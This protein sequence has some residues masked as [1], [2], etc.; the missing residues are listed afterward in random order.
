MDF[1]K[2]NAAIAPLDRQAM[3]MARRRWDNL[4]KPIGSMGRMEQLIVRLAGIYGGSGIDIGKRALLVMCADNGVLAQ[5]VAQTPAE[6]TATMAGFIADG[7][8][9]AALMA[10]RA[11]CEVV[12]VDMGMLRKSQNPR[13][14]DRRI[15]AATN[16]ISQGAAMSREQALAAINAGV[17]LVRELHQ[18]GYRL[19][20]TGEMGIGNTTTTAAMAAALLGL[21]PQSVTGRG[22]G[23]SDEGLRNKQ[24][25]VARALAV[26]KPDASDALDVLHKLGG[27]DIA[28]LSGV[29]IGGALCRIPVLVDGVISSI[30][31]LTAARLV[32]AARAMMLPS[33]LSAEPCARAILRELELE[34]VIDGQMRLGEGSGAMLLLP[35]LDLTLD[36]YRRLMTFADIGM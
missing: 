7:R 35:L 33:H 36:V 10:A 6:I 18:R 12:T 17:E 16:D 15:A 27:F 4:A 23:L 9:A 5:G 28:G 2:L 1:A 11:N 13:I 22:V 34:P 3:E 32:P 20:A 14:L 21:A 25:V 31:A 29:F 19:L 24:Q 26:N 30:A 8:S